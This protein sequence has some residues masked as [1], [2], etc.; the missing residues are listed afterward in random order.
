MITIYHLNSSRSE[1]IIWLMEELALPYALHTLHRG[2]DALA[3]PELKDIHPLG[4]APVIRDGDTVLAESGAIVE[5]IIARHGEGRLAVTPFEPEFARYL[6]WLHYA[7][8]SLM[9][10]LLRESTLERLLPEP[11]HTPGMARIR[12]ATWQ[13]L[14]FIDNALQTSA[15]FAGDRFTAADLMMAFPFTTLRQ[16]LPHPPDLSAYPALAAYLQR[17]ETRP[18]YERAMAVAG[19]PWK[20]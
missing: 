15:Y 2:P 1:R 6:Y 9:L 17:I 5:Y 4:R 13:H 18:A 10:Q 14:Q 11:D 8:G 20:T 19:P 16:F 3:P 12:A 7:E